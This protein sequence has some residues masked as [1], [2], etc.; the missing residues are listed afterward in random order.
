MRAVIV[1][2]L[3]VAAGL[4]V[5][6]VSAAAPAVDRAPLDRFPETVASWSG[7]DLPALDDRTA[8]VLGADEYLIRR[9]M[10][11]GEAPVDLFIAYYGQQR[12]GDAIHSP[13]NCLPGA[14]WRPVE[15]SRVPLSTGT[16]ETVTV[17]RYVIE[18]ALDRRVVFYWYQ[19]RGRIV[20]SEYANK[21]WLMLDAMRAGRTDGALVRLI[22]TERGERGA[23]GFLADAF[24]HLGGVIP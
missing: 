3:I 1:A 6:A 18:K 11:D 9:Y 20:A 16:G 13:Q 23:L 22:T 19:G 4:Y 2:V 8:R 17:N 5:R 14:G 24:N 15:E 12:Q 7:E 10:Q 21:G